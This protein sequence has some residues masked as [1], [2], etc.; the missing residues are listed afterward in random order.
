MLNPLVLN[1]NK[2]KTKQLKTNDLQRHLMT[3]GSDIYSNQ[4]L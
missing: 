4:S 2:M 1:E 3:L